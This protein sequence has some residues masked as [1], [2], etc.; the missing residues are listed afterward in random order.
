MEFRDLKRQY[1]YLKTDIDKN[2]TALH[3][4]AVKR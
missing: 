1:E 3:L 2:I 4:L